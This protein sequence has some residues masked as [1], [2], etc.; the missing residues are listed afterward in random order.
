VSDAVIVAL[1]VAL[2]SSPLVTALAGRRTR[3]D[4]REAKE[5]AGSARVVASAALSTS[6]DALEAIGHPNGHG[7]AM[8]MLGQILE[9]QASIVT[10]Q[11]GQDRRLA[12]LE[13]TSNNHEG[14]ISGL[15]RRSAP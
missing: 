7:T 2:S 9:G 3:R 13:R 6:T 5:A 8:E 1:I 10:G 15:E 11:A 14:R 12:A 4:A